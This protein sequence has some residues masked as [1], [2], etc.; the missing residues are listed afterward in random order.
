M[1]K[2][3]QLLNQKS[4]LTK[5]VKSDNLALKQ[6]IP[7]RI[8]ALENNE[9]E[10]LVYEKWFGNTVSLMEDLIQKPMMEELNTLKMLQDR[11]SETISNIDEQI[12]KLTKEFE[13]MQSEL[14]KL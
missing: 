9:V 11:Y 3:E 14:V 2:V 7:E 13:L 12:E 8:K 1:K 5:E 10:Q 4:S 6:K